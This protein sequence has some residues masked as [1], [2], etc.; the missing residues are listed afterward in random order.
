MGV[1]SEGAR[2]ILT[3]LGGAQDEALDVSMIHIP[4]VPEV[5]HQHFPAESFGMKSLVDVEN[6][7]EQGNIKGSFESFIGATE[8]IL[9]SAQCLYGGGL[10]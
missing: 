7:Q 10:A 1:S 4:V 5:M 8:K 6:G 2:K 9:K 3:L